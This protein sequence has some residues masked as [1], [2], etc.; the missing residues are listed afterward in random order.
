LADSKIPGMP[1]LI[2]VKLIKSGL[3]NIIRTNLPDNNLFAN[4]SSGPRKKKQLALAPFS[5]NGY[6]IRY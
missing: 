5:T 4:N 2:A 6:D 3:E 1:Y